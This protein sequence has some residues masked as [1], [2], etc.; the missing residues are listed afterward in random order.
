[1]R[2]GPAV[3]LI[4]ALALSG[5]ATPVCPAVAT[6]QASQGIA[7]TFDDLPAHNDL[8][9]GETRLGVIARLVAA[10]A[11]AGAPPT[12]GFVNASTASDPA[13]AGVLEVWRAAGNPVG[14]HTWSHRN[15][16]RST[17]ETFIA[18]ITRNEPA[19][20]AMDPGGD[21]RWFR[22]PYL[23]EGD[24][25]EKRAAIRGW[26]ADHDYRVASV[27][28][29]FDDYAWNGPYARCVARGDAS[30]IAALEDS[31]LT[32]ADDSLT[33]ARRASMEQYG[34]EI[35]LVLLLHVG[36]FDARMAPRLLALYKARGVRLVTLEQA[37]QDPA[38][39]G[40]LAGQPTPPPLSAAPT[41]S[42]ADLFARLDALCRGDGASG[43]RP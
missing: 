13:N 15:L 21:W 16:A 30:G 1:M 38:Y 26:L 10:L 7:L 22:Y 23:S 24:T 37:E 35:P 11:D 6:A 18:E 28:L 5:A 41:A 39:A 29:S 42:R 9:V 25:P 32:A 14:N 20:E 17:P 4:A 31:Y 12:Y 3:R 33:A 19:L 36:A 2:F 40:E 43:V 8:P 34:R 27:T